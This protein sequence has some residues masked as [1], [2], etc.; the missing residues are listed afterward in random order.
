MTTSNI[1]TNLPRVRYSDAELAEFR[2]LIEDKLQVALQEFEFAKSQISEANEGS[3]GQQSG[4]WTDESTNH[5]EIE[6]LNNMISRQAAFIQN[7]RNALL[8]IQNKTYGVCVIT[9]QLIDKKRLQ[10]VP[11]ATKSVEAKNSR[12][13]QNDGQQGAKNSQATE[14]WREPDTTDKG[15]VPK[16]YFD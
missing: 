1:K 3:R 12:P 15:E 10:L 4:D 6:L 5:T 14:E 13:S 2:S 9:G 7:L 8:R 11:H 16:E